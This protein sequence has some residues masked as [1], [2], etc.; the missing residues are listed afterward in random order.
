M[1][2]DSTSGEQITLTE[3]ATLTRAF[4]AEFPNEI[5]ASFIGAD[6]IMLILDQED[7]IGIRI[8]NGYDETERTMSLVM[9]GVDSS[10]VDMTSGVI[11]DRMI[12]CPTVCDLTSALM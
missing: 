2:L 6:N 5:K 11:L 3:A 9:V 4:R 7:C 10:G 1:A 12:K 8:Y